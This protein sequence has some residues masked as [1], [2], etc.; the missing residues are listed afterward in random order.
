MTSDQAQFSFL[1]Y[2]VYLD[3]NLWSKIP[4]VD[5]VFQKHWKFSFSTNAL[6][7]IYKQLLVFNPELIAQYLAI[8][9]HYF[10]ILKS[11]FSFVSTE[12]LWHDH[13]YNQQAKDVLF[14]NRL[15]RL[16]FL[17]I[18]RHCSRFRNSMSLA[19]WS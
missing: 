15:Q 2:A 12:S 6:K 11:Q 7:N 10:E 8:I 4:L 5:G 14:R 17:V 13:N 9:N 18:E 3:L 1:T 19:C 16:S